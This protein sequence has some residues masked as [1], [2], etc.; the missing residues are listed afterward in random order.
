MK[1]KYQHLKIF[2]LLLL[3]LFVAPCVYA[4]Q[5]TDGDGVI[6]TVDI[7]D[8][9]DGILDVDECSSFLTNFNNIIEGLLLGNVPNS[10]IVQNIVGTVDVQDGSRV[11]VSPPVPP[12]EGNKF[13][14]F[15]TQNNGTLR[16]ETW[17]LELQPA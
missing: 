15:H 9:N 4:Q 13:I 12:F 3:F 16:F 10:G 2:S 5:D 6:D 11:S 8:D 17:S 1:K 7:D 14:A